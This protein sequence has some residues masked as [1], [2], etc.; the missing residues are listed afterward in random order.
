MSI[1]TG[2]DGYDPLA[3]FT[4]RTAREL[5]D[6]RSEVFRKDTNPQVD[7]IEFV[8]RHLIG[9]KSVLELGCGLGIWSEVARQVGCW[10]FGVDG[11]A[12]RVRYAAQRF[13][14]KA[15]TYPDL[16]VVFKTG[17]IR[18]IRLAQKFDTALFVTVLQHMT[19][20]GALEALDTAA[21]HL[22]PDSKVI[23]IE[24][25]LMDGTIEDA[26]AAY[27]DPSCSPHMI[28]KPIS[29]LQAQIPELDWNH[30]GGDRYILTRV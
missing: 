25:R 7:E 6:P 24:S 8:R 9:R 27:A 20:Q 18:T 13:S 19:L 10:Y 17:D 26:E 1:W 28:P 2:K 4:D 22:W 29:V 30:L 16:S 14:G 12:E 3:E 11:V 21:R 15:K 23:M 5:A